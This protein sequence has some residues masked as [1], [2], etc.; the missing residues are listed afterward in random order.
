MRSLLQVLLVTAAA[1]GLLAGIVFG[2]GDRTIFVSPP[3]AVAEQFMRKV[4][5]ER[6]GQALDHLESS[7]QQQVSEEGLRRGM[8]A[9]ERRHGP[10]SDVRGEF[11]SIEGDE[12]SASA[13]LT[14]SA[15]GEVPLR[16]RLKRSQG[17]W[18]ISDVTSLTGAEGEL[19]R[20]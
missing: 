7:L 10:F 14:T 11:L 15:G 1:L 18:E 16:F 3:E 12:A 20:R 9:L 8:E 19:T 2:L 17:S 6:F 5:T 4:E 13:V